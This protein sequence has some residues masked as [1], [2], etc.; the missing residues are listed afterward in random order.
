MA[1]EENCNNIVRL[2][3]NFIFVIG[4]PIRTGVYQD[5]FCQQ[6]YWHSTQ[7]QDAEHCFIGKKKQFFIL[8]LN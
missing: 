8:I 6:E 7:F 5:E 3:D 1:K 4:K 2:I